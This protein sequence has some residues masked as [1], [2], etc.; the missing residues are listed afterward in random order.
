M[1]NNFKRIWKEVEFSWRD[2]VKPQRI[3]VRV[4]D[5]PSK[6]S[7]DQSHFEKLMVTQL[8]K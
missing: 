5:I 8:L 1:I 7:K 6:N 4:G 2:R 3:L